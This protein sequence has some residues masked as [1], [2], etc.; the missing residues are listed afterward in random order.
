[1]IK[2]LAV[3]LFVVSGM[4]YALEIDIDEVINIQT[5]SVMPDGS[6]G[7]VTGT[8][9]GVTSEPKGDYRVKITNGKGFKSKTFSE[10]HCNILP[11][12]EIKY[13]KGESI[14]LA[15][16]FTVKGELYNVMGFYSGTDIF[17][18]DG[19]K[20]IIKNGKSRPEWNSMNCRIK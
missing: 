12:D 14:P 15:T 5:V 2:F 4:S 9:T 3:C 18:V 6:F 13:V 1:M 20:V 11:L 16:V 7:T 8:V 19:Y 10:M 17:P